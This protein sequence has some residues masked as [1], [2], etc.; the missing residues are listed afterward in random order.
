MIKETPITTFSTFSLKYSFKNEQ[1]Q[2]FLVI[3]FN[4]GRL[5]IYDI[6]HEKKEIKAVMMFSCPNVQEGLP[7]LIN[8]TNTNLVG[9]SFTDP[10]HFVKL[11][12]PV[13]YN[14]LI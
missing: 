9:K 8:T 6:F 3:A 11:N 14:L 10:T 12:P 5:A 7:Y 4:D 2:K 1:N 13:K